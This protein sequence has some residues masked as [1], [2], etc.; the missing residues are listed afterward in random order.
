MMRKIKKTS[1]DGY[2]ALRVSVRTKTFIDL[3]GG[4]GVVEPL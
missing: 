1:F 2:A 3:L 4:N